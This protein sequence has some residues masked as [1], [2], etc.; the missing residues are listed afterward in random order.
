MVQSIEDSTL[1]NISNHINY[2][3]QSYILGFQGFF[4]IGKQYMNTLNPNLGAVG[5]R[6]GMVIPPPVGFPLI[7][8][9]Q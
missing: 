1:Q 6:G 4:F 7:T 2:K 5:K 9:K 3:F 8:H